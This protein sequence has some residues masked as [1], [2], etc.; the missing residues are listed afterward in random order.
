MFSGTALISL[1]NR[2]SISTDLKIN[3]NAYNYKQLVCITIIKYTFLKLKVGTSH[4]IVPDIKF[5]TP[6][7]FYSFFRAAHLPRYSCSAGEMSVLFC[8]KTNTLKNRFWT[9]S[10]EL[11]VSGLMTTPRC[12]RRAIFWIL[13]LL[14]KR[15]LFSAMV[16]YILF[17]SLINMNIE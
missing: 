12:D 15:I 1:T 3:E 2:Y 7:W 5:S 16:Y 13:I 9:R 14:V 4:I 8:F 6:P 17:L 11:V 10:I